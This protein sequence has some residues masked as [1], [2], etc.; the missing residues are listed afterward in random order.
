MGLVT[1]KDMQ[2]WYEKEYQDLEW[3][4]YIREVQMGQDTKEHGIQVLTDYSITRIH[5]AVEHWMQMVQEPHRKCK[6]DGKNV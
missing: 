1:Y 4:E 2:R 6:K 3:I 5:R